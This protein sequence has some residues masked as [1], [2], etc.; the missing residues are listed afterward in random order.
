MKVVATYG[1]F[2]LF[3]EGHV[4]LLR[5]AKALGDYLIVGVTTN[6]Y[7]EIR[8]KLNTTDS[9]AVRYQAVVDS[10]FADEV[11]PEEYLG[12]KIDDVKTRGID[13]MVFGSNWIGHFDYLQGMCEV[14]YLP[15][16]QGISST[17]LRNERCPE[18]SLGIVGT[19]RIARRFIT[20]AAGVGGKQLVGVYNPN[21]EH[22]QEFARESSLPQAFDDYSLFLDA[23][24]AVYVASPHQNHCEQTKSALLAGKH[25]LCEK[26]LALSRAQAEELFSLARERDL[27]LLEAVKTAYCPGFEE[28]VDVVRSGVIGEVRDMEA[29]FTR[30]TPPG[31]R[32][33]DD[34]RF[35]GSF[36]EFGS[37]GLLPAV[38]L[39]GAE[40]VERMTARFYTQ[41]D[42]AGVDLFTK[43]M[44][45]DENVAVLAKTGLGVKAEGEL[46]ISGTEG[47]ILARAPWWCTTHFEVHKEDPD[48]VQIY[49]VAFLGSGLRYEISNFIH[50]VRGDDDRH[51]KLSAEESIAM[52]GVFERYLEGGCS[53]S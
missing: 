23:V 49:E 35:G 14:V 12:Q 33:R 26:P 4:N 36:L 32:E 15:R 24:D 39:L 11:I 52:A 16:T 7:D 45:S 30:L 38:R 5:R 9:Y 6:H 41:R 37:Y 44:L 34:A 10:G 17:A 3:H 13:V 47:Y 27:V 50:L 42:E 28:L 18:V 40:R 1:V 2:D 43:A 21:A 29:T 48:D 46:L 19:G 20:E 53:I 8:G 25:V 51:P 31:V 22:A